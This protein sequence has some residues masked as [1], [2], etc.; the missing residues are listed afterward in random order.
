[1][2]NHLQRIE[3]WKVTRFVCVVSMLSLIGGYAWLLM[4]GTITG[5]F[6]HLSYIIFAF[7]FTALVYIH[8][9][10]RPTPYADLGTPSSY[11][12]INPI[13]HPYAYPPPPAHLRTSQTSILPQY[14]PS[15]DFCVHPSSSSSPLSPAPPAYV[16]EKS[17][18]IQQWPRYVK[19][20]QTCSLLRIYRTR[21]LACPPSRRLCL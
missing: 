19:D 9:T 20:F 2:S 8:N 17:G 6:I 13:Q 1:M 15:S 11:P 12:P 10:R 4:S 14:T 16:E 7:S 18:S 3:S 5:P 21:S